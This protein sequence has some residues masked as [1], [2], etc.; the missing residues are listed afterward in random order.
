MQKPRQLAAGP[1]SESLIRTADV[2]GAAATLEAWATGA[3]ASMHIIEPTGILNTD[4]GQAILAKVKILTTDSAE[5]VW[6]DCHSVSFMDSMGLGC[7]IQALKHVRD[8]GK[9]IH[10]CR[11]NSQL[12]TVL[13]LTNAESVFS[14][15]GELPS[16]HA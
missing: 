1:E 13:E 12:K 2:T 4:Q 9:T 6:I 3:F 15:M 5:D 8:H 14:I 10:L 11:I 16:K 7:L